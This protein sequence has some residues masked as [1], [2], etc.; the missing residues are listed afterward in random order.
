MGP[1]QDAYK[2]E[3]TFYEAVLIR[4]TPSGVWFFMINFMLNGGNPRIMFE[5]YAYYISSDIR[6]S[7]SSARR[8]ELVLRL[9]QISDSHGGLLLRDISFL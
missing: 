3:K 2:Q 8:A 7:S 9:F 5:K 1:Y 4:L 6:N